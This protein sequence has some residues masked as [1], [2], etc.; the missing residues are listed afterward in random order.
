MTPQAEILSRFRP[1]VQAIGRLPPDKWAGWIVWA[2]NCLD[3]EPVGEDEKRV[4]FA[5]I[6]KALETRLTTGKW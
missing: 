1:V 4:A 3:V 6:G 2:L 5:E